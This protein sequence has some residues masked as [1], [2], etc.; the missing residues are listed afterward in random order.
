MAVTKKTIEEVA[1]EYG[2]DLSEQA[3]KKYAD[4]YIQPTL[5]E[6]NQA[7][8]QAIANTQAAR[9]ALE[10]DYFK[11]YRANTYSA[12]SRGLT[13]GLAQMDNQLLRMQVGQANADLTKN[14]LMSQNQAAEQRGTALSN[15]EVYKTNYLDNLRGKVAQLQQA[16]YEQRYKEWQDAQ[17]LA[18]AEK[19]FAENQRRWE[20]EYAMSKDRYNME[21]DQFE[22]N[23]SL[24]EDE[25][26]QNELQYDAN[27]K[28]YLAMALPDVANTYMAYMATDYQKAAEYLAQ[29][30][31]NLSKKYGANPSEI[32]NQVTNIGRYNEAI[33]TLADE[34]IQTNLKKAR[35]NAGWS[36]FSTWAAS[37]LAAATAIPTGG[38]S[39]A[40]NVPVAT[41]TDT[42]RR[43]NENAYEK[44]KK[45]LEDAEK[46]RDELGRTLPSWYVSYIT[47]NS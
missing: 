12:Q 25:K 38:L 42:N 30:A 9:K 10:N 13:G 4:A 16:D 43:I 46:T 33:D 31:S 14:L 28:E 34:D 36:N 18:Q 27:V 5:T 44:Y 41:W 37:I 32:I 19:E 15:A 47:P 21:K 2:Y 40:A 35:T 29:Q 45:I 6:I 8:Q 23:K 39:L 24:R 1:D 22:Y 11:Q 20:L 7:E 17:A 26:K 3:A